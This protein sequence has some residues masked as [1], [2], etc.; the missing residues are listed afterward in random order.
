MWQ[1]PKTDWKASDFLISVIIT[2]LRVTSTKYGTWP[3]PSG[4]ILSLRRWE[5]I[6]PIRIMGFM[7]MK[8]TALRPI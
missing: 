6:R 4:R 5:R 1:Q 7:P 2:A 3:L 8:L